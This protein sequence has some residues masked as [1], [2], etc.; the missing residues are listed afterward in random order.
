MLGTSTKNAPVSRFI[1]NKDHKKDSLPLPY[2]GRLYN[3]LMGEGSSDQMYPKGGIQKIIDAIIASFPKNNVEIKTN[4]KAIAIDVDENKTARNVITDKCEYECDAVIYSGF[5]SKLPNIIKS[6]KNC[7]P[8]DYIQNL[9]N[10]KKVNS[11]SIWLGLKKKIFKRYGSEM[12]IT[13][14]PDSNPYTWVI[15][16]SNYDANLAPMGKQLVGFAFIVPDDCA[17]ADMRKK[18]IESIFNTIPEI[19]KNVEMMHY[20]ELV[21]EKACWSINSG[22]GDVKTPIKNLYCIGSDSEKRS[23]GLTRSSY[24]VLRM[25]EIM[26]SDGNL[27]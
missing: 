24:S 18:A 17:M 26:K 25:I 13:L 6:N 16:T 20:Q 3:L 8:E 7:M 4:E 23:M 10:I 12:W 2:I 5:S 21:P 9:R 11:L 15:P 1:D 19:E 14:D 27:R 22:F